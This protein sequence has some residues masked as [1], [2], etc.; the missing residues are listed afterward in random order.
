[1]ILPIAGIVI[2]S[3]KFKIGPGDYGFVSIQKSGASA[4]NF[5]TLAWVTLLLF[6]A[7]ELTS[8]YLW[9]H[10]NFARPE[11]TYRHFI[12]NGP[13]R[14]YVL[15]YFSITASL[16]EEM[17]Y[18]GMFWRALSG[19]SSRYRVGLYV[20]GSSV[21]FGAIHWE[22]GWP[23]VIAASVF[24]IVACLI[25]HRIH[26]LWPLVLAHFVTDLRAFA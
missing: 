16:V 22:N 1:M 3:R 15:L 20:I 24:G 6:S 13:A 17:F 25:Y 9:R 19:L 2:L 4:F 11:V 8:K 7:Y 21:L 23:E 5:I 14:P 12:P 26:T 10:S 18:R